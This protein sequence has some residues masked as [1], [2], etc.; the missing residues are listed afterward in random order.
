MITCFFKEDMNHLQFN[1]W[2]TTIGILL[3][4]GPIT[5]VISDEVLRTKTNSLPYTFTPVGLYTI[6]PR[7]SHS[8]T[9][10]ITATMYSM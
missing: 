7:S 10:S 8:I 9:Y 2:D 1:Y 3:L 4:K 5:T 6:A